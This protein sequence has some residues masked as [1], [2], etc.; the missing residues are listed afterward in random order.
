MSLMLHTKPK[1]YWPL[2]PEKKIFW[3]FLPYTGVGPSWSCDPDVAN[4][5]SFPWPMKVSYEIWLWLA[6]WFLRRRHL[7]SVD[8]G[9]TDDRQTDSEA[10][11][12]YKLTYE[13]KSSG[14]LKLSISFSW[15]SV[16]GFND[17]STLVGHFVS[18][19][20]EREK[21]DRRDS[22]RDERE[23]QGR[24][25]NM[26]ESVETEEIKNHLPTLTCYKDSRPCPTVSWTPRWHK[27]H[28]TFAPPVERLMHFIWSYVVRKK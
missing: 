24:K 25:R 23:G 21:R 18:S 27:I 8:D 15:K 10:C 14:E 2:V 9:R 17:T 7:K 26:N 13:P 19:P 5:L 16:L 1:G 4:K 20:R 6:K 22:R 28:D 3:R 11:L 12:Y